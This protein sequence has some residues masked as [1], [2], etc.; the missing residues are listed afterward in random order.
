[1]LA[2]GPAWNSLPLHLHE[3]EERNE[4]PKGNLYNFSVLFPPHLP[5]LSHLLFHLLFPLSPLPSPSPLPSF[6][7]LLPLPFLFSTSDSPLPSSMSQ[8]CWK[9]VGHTQNPQWR[10]TQ[11]KLNNVVAHVSQSSRMPLTALFQTG[12]TVWVGVEGRRNNAS[13][14]QK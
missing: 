11:W 1:M 4:F 13:C 10:H 8:A 2:R 6:P 3:V 14:R 12:M 5:F 9:Q 7:P